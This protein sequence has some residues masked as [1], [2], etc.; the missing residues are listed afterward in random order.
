MSKIPLRLGAEDAAEDPQQVADQRLALRTAPERHPVSG[1]LAVGFGL[2]GVF[3]PGLLFTPLGFI[4]SVIAL[5]RGQAT[6]GFVGLLLTVAGFL[7]SP[8]LMG[9]VGMSA[10]FVFFD[11]Q[12]ILAPIYQMLGGGIDV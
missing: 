5:F 8:L 9:L 1:Y 11:W 10:F 3:G 2:L 7:S 6:W 4:F 12:D